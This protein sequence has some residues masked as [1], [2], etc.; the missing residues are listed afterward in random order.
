VRLIGYQ[1]QSRVRAVSSG[2]AVTVD[3]SLVK[4]N[5]SLAGVIVTA[6]TIALAAVLGGCDLKATNPG[7]LLDENLDTA[8]A[9]PTLVNGM[10]GSVSIAI[11]NYLP[12]GSLAAREL[13][14]SGNFAAERKFAAGD[15]AKVDS[16]AIFPSTEREI[17]VYRQLSSANELYVT[18]I[19]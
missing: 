15:I 6:T 10:G 12:R 18:R 9:G 11:G 7:P 14:H 16:F 4:R 17:F 1:R 19:Q 3:F 5:T 2:A 13:R 8:S